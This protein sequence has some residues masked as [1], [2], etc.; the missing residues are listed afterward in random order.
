MVR[1]FLI[2]ENSETEFSVDPR[3]GRRNNTT[4]SAL[5]EMGAITPSVIEIFEKNEHILTKLKTDENGKKIK[6]LR[7]L[8]Y[9]SFKSWSR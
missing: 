6:K 8:Y 3:N 2:L 9:I 1:H 7:A 4:R 5:V